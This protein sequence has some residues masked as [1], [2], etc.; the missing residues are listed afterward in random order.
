M[1]VRNLFPGKTNANRATAGSRTGIEGRKYPVD[2]AAR[3]NSDR[4]FRKK[5]CKAVGKPVSDFLVA[6]AGKGLPSSVE[7]VV[8]GGRKV[9]PKTSLGIEWKDG[10]KTNF[11]VSTSTESQIHLAVAES[12]IEEFAAQFGLEIPEKVKDAL[13]LFCGS[14][15]RQREILESVPVECVGAKTRQKVEANYF[16]RLTLASMYGYDDAM[17]RSLLDWFRRN[18]ADLFMFCFAWGA[19]KG[20]EHGA[21]FMWYRVGEDGFK[22]FNLHAIAKRLRK[23]MSSRGYATN[24]IRPNDKSEIGSTIAFP[25]GNLQQHENKLQF[26]HSLAL[27]ESLSEIAGESRHFGSRQKVSGH[28]NEEM[29]ADAL[30][31]NLQFREHF[32]E[33]VGRL[34]SDFAGAEAGGESAPKVPGVL[35]VKT[36]PKTD[37]V[38]K[39]KD[40]SRTNISLKKS[41][42][43]Q[44]YLVKASHFAEVYEKQYGRAF[45]PK[46]RRALELFVGEDSECNSILART[47]ISIDG[48]KTRKQ[49][50]EKQHCRLVFEVLR[51]YDPDMASGLLAWLKDE[52][53]AVCELTF[54]AGAVED[55]DEWAHVL[56]YKNLVDADGQGLDYLVPIK[57]INEALKRKGEGNVVER[58]PRNAGSTIKLPFGHLQYHHQQLEFY[59]HLKD[60]QS[61]NP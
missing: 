9:Q 30:N 35:G 14:H 16:C 60:I 13:R 56:W 1:S 37:V 59:Q 15:P 22:I 32:C 31:R 45:P 4:D 51:N 49:A 41:P 48:E 24:A 18:C 39:W 17:P 7:N 6:R 55:R 19:M 12:F 11:R 33:R 44:A 27:I 43:G 28:K 50:V 23:L 38:V 8:R 20:R 47:D 53:V 10:S 26:R 58:G 21:D 36:T 2:V 61:L 54:A 40:G 46:V 25:F 34:P 42:L 29:I 57:R 52:I 5:V 3:L